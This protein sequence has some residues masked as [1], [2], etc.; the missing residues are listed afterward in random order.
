MLPHQQGARLIQD[1]T[2]GGLTA[3]T[4]TAATQLLRDG[5]SGT[6]VAGD[7]PLGGCA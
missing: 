6:I 2:K 1:R 5:R 3:A 4:Q 7:A